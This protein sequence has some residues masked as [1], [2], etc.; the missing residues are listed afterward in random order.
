MFRSYSCL[1]GQTVF[2]FIRWICEKSPGDEG[3]L[4]CVRKCLRDALP[5]NDNT[6]DICEAPGWY[7]EDHFVC[8]WECDYIP[9]PY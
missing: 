4:E 8:W 2:I 6:P 3:K 7:F 5:P 9:W 1:F